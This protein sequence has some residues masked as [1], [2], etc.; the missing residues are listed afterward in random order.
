[1]LTTCTSSY[2]ITLCDNNLYSHKTFSEEFVVF[3]FLKKRQPSHRFSKNMGANFKIL[4]TE[5]VFPRV[6]QLSK[7]PGLDDKS[8][9][10]EIE[11]QIKMVWGGSSLFEVFGVYGEDTLTVKRRA[12]I[13]R[14]KPAGWPRKFLLQ[15]SSDLTSNFDRFLLF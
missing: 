10:Y 14:F 2:E 4:I 1:M 13:N 3:L 11:T 5:W 9:K 7:P 15:L 6:S 12:T 8:K